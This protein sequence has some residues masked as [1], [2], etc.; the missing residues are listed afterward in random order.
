VRR[1]LATPQQDHV[2]PYPKIAAPATALVPA[3]KLD[4]RSRAHGAGRVPKDRQIAV[5][6]PEITIEEIDRVIAAG[7][8]FGCVLA[9]SG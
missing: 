4:E 9:D 2:E 6:K 8:R 1:L 7:A 5:T 3:R